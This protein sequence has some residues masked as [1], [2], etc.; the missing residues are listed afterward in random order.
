MKAFAHGKCEMGGPVD[1][2]L[3]LLAGWHVLIG[4]HSPFRRLASNSTITGAAHR[5][6]RDLDMIPG[7]VPESCSARSQ[8]RHGDCCPDVVVTEPHGWR[9]GR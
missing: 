2:D 1:R 3:I 6:Y 7:M 4:L 8:R 5:H 9:S